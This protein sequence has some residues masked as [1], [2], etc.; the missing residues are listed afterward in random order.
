MASRK[1]SDEHYVIDLCDEILGLKASRQHTFDFL[2]GDGEPGR[3]LPVD[4]Y[5]PNLKLVVEYKER[6]HTESVA[7]FNKE[8]TVSGVSRDEQRRIY[9]QRR[10][11]VLPKHGIQ[12]IEISYTDLKHDNRKRLIRSRQ[13]DIAVIRRLLSVAQNENYFIKPNKQYQ[14]RLDIAVARNRRKKSNQ[15]IEHK[16]TDKQKEKDRINSL[17]SKKPVKDGT[18]TWVY[19]VYSKHGCLFILVVVFGSILLSCYLTMSVFNLNEAL[20]FIIVFVFSVVVSYIFHLYTTG[21]DEK[22]DKEKYKRK[23]ISSIYNS[24]N[25]YPVCCPQCGSFNIGPTDNG[26]FVCF[27]CGLQWYQ[28][29]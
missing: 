7:F 15:K 20:S 24:N 21:V 12:L 28:T 2:R 10:R 9:D 1:N 11:D 19:S 25:H 13:E 27:D 29:Y 5:Y 18:Q 16:N 14:T 8:T 17:E 23:G 26:G 22:L 3:K 6:Q 4:A